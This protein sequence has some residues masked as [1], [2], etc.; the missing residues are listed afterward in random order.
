MFWSEGDYVAW[1]SPVENGSAV[2]HPLH[3]ETVQ[4]MGHPEFVLSQVP[5]DKEEGCVKHEIEQ[6]YPDG[7]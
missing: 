7:A 3:D 2:S 4:W 1:E 6:T 5:I